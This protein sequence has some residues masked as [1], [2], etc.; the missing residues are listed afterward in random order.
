MTQ[1]QDPKHKLMRVEVIAK[2]R[3]SFAHGDV[4]TSVFANED[5]YGGFDLRMVQQREYIWIGERNYACSFRPRDAID[6][7]NSALEANRLM[8]EWQ[9]N[10]RWRRPF[11][12]F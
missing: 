5:G 2:N 11:A 7:S 9:R 4:V 10:S 6:V 1:K 12:W 8:Q 3:E